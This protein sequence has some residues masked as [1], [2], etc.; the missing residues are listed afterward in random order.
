MKK[1]SASKDV[2]ISALYAQ[3]F[4]HMYKHTYIH[5]YAHC[6]HVRTHFDKVFSHNFALRIREIFYGAKRCIVARKDM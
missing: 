4:I 5:A 2:A 3:V 6:T 1:D